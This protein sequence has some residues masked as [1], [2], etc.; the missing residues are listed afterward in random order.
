MSAPPRIVLRTDPVLRVPADHE[1]ETIYARANE[2][3]GV[4][5][6]ERAFRDIC[7]NV[8]AFSAITLSLS[9]APIESL[10]GQS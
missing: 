2:R 5:D 8:S 6:H 10:G 1:D 7:V 4:S 9:L 3:L